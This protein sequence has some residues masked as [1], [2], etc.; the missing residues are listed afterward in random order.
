MGRK[1]MGHIDEDASDMDLAEIEELDFSGSAY[2][3][4]AMID[5][6]PVDPR[7]VLGGGRVFERFSDNIWT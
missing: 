3:G 4:G 7:E 2:G 6:D 5:E 1:N